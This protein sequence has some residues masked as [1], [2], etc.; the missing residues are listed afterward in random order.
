M[1]EVDKEMRMDRISR[2]LRELRYEVERGFMESEIDE[3][4]GYE[5]IV[6]ISRKIT[7]GVVWCRFETRPLHR[8]SM[9]GKNINFEPKLKIVE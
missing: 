8:D 4:I 9:L 3:N 1:S 7:N 5:F 6:P 2:L